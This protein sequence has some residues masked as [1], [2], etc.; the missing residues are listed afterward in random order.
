ME[1]TEAEAAGGGLTWVPLWVEDKTQKL[2]GQIV[3]S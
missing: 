3:Y 2:I 1:S